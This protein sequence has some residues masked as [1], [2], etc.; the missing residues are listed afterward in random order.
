MGERD[1]DGISE[2]SG[3]WRNPHDPFSDP[4]E[5]K[6]LYAAIDSFKQY[7]R[8]NHLTL[9]HLR[10]QAFY[11]LPLQHQALLSSQPISL[12]DR[13]T[14]IDDA[15]DTNAE[16]AEEIHMLAIRGLGLKE[17][18]EFSNPTPAATIPAT[19]DDPPEDEI[20]EYAYDWRST[21][22]PS[23]HSKSRTT[24]A[25]FYRDWSAAGIHE[26]NV[27]YRPLLLDLI[28]EFPASS[29]R[30]EIQV[31]VPGAG[32]GRLLFE[33]CRLGFSAEGND[34]SYHALLASNWALNVMEGPYTL[35]PFVSGFTNQISRRENKGQLQCVKIPD[36]CPGI[37]LTRLEDSSSPNPNIKEDPPSTDVNTKTTEKPAPTPQTQLLDGQKGGT[38]SMTAADFVSAYSS[39]TNRSRYAVVLTSFFI[40]TLPNVLR[41]IECVHNVLVPGGIWANVGPLMWHFD[42]AGVHPIGQNE[43]LKMKVKKDEDW[44]SLGIAEAGCVELTDEE[45]LECVARMG[46]VVESH[47]VSG[48]EDGDGRTGYIGDSESMLVQEYR[49]SHWVAR[50]VGL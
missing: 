3:E 6:V 14:S 18:C 27:C 8:H 21:A 9:T 32:L 30:S 36:I 46:F 19:E 26:R 34:I 42:G 1:D 23:D 15:I 33:V 17:A 10:R 20:E 40:D 35:F 28:H 39:P 16:I 41:A 25:Q 11:A 7:R 37:E 38:M 45:V 12:L 49:V 31:L 22:T 44:G 24:V 29:R 13:L 50:K 47:E 5:T 43:K 48:A 4:E 2:G